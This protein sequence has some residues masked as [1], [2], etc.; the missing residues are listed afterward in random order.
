LIHTLCRHIC[1]TAAT[2]VAAT[3]YLTRAST[4]TGQNTHTTCPNHAQPRLV[5]HIPLQP[6]PLLLLLLLLLRFLPTCTAAAAVDSFAKMMGNAYNMNGLFGV[7]TSQLKQMN[8]PEQ[9]LQAADRMRSNFRCAF[10]ECNT[11]CVILDAYC[12][13]EA[14]LVQ[15]GIAQPRRLFV[16][17]FSHSRHCQRQNSCTVQVAPASCFS[18]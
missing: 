4:E 11:H 17:W 10:E 3:V 1:T 14:W 16:R 2:L 6:L 5:F 9:Y 12:S 7:D 13:A 15:N 8:L 18:S